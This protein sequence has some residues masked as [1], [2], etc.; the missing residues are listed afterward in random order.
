MKNY[1]SLL[2]AALVGTTVLTTS[3]NDTFRDDNTDPASVTSADPRFLFSQAVNEFD[4]S[5][6]LLWYYNAN[7][8]YTLVQ[9]TVPGGSYQESFYNAT[10]QQGY[11]CINVKNYLHIM[12][13][14]ISKMSEEDQARKQGIHAALSTLVT[15]LAIVDA[16]F[17]G[18]MPYTEASQARFGGTLT[19][20]YDKVSELYDLWLSDLDKNVQIFTSADATNQDKIGTQDVIYGGDWNKWAKLANSL[21]LKIAARL[22]SQNF[23]KAKSIVASVKS[24]SCGVI[25]GEADDFLFNKAYTS[26]GNGSNSDWIYQTGNGLGS[27]YANKAVMD[28]MINNDDPR[29]RFI[30]TKNSYNSKIVDAFLAAG[31]KDQLPAYIM[32]NVATKV[33]DGKE[34]FDHW[35]GKG[36]PWVRYYGTPAV[37]KKESSA[38]Y[39]DWFD[40]NK[41]KLDDQHSYG[42][43]SGIQN[44]MLQGR[45]DFTLPVV[46]G[47]PIIR[48]TDDNP[49]YGRFLG[50]AEVNLYLAE[51]A[52]YEGNTSEAN[53]YFKKALEA[54]VNEYDRLAS[55]NKIPYYGTTYGYDP[56]EVSIEL[57][58]GEIETMLSHADYQLSGDKALDLEKVYL[59]QLINFTLQPADVYVTA[60]RSGVP[61]FKSDLVRRADFA[62]NNIPVTLLPRRVAIPAVTDTDL[63]KDIKISAY[64][65]QGFTVPFTEASQLNSERVWQDV[66]APQWGE[67]PI[68]K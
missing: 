56:N 26:T 17:A 21:K 52:V 68:V 22:I 53:R 30:Y 9:L 16:D 59:Q 12:E 49:W 54:S 38:E 2:L 37:F 39:S 41:A 48:D 61:T 19:P 46:P 29:V 11:K 13:N 58:S 1:K 40:S 32:A 28:F 14:E 67:G 24:A 60:R 10:E 57:K 20:K 45:N 50:T 7:S 15:Y 42:R 23:D 18:D 47:D 33:V 65:S 63:M 64:Q 8:F 31:K 3:C 62:E 35:T 51:F 5:S 44:E 43:V 25:D 55:L 4:P 34:V 66:G 36:E 27:F 6:Y